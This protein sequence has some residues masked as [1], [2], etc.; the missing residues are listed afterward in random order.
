MDPV[1]TVVI[2]TYNRARKLKRSL[3]SVRA[4]TYSN[5]E[6]VVVDNHSCDNTD[7]VVKNFNDTRIRLFKVHNEGVIAVSRNL[8]VKQARGEYIAFLDSDDWWAPQKL[9]Y[10]LKQLDLGVDL[11]Y[12]DMYIA[13]REQQKWFL[14]KTNDHCLQGDVFNDLIMNGPSMVNSSV[15]VR[16]SVLQE[17]G[18]LSEDAGLVAAEDYD[19]WLRI[20]RHTDKFAKVLKVLGFLWRGGESISNAER[21]IVILNTLECHYSREI[22]SL[23]GWGYAPWW[24]NYSRGRAYYLLR[25]YS[26]AKRALRKINYW[27]VPVMIAVKTLWM[28]LVSRMVT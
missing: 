4:Q 24:I 9:Y 26:E 25:N 22:N 1:I 13:T 2:P 16:K 5:W 3:E 17:V 18:Y 19:L 12:H 7:E 20:A 11:V 14:K 10:S 23:I 15:V 27:K 6:V 28:M 8:G 21:T